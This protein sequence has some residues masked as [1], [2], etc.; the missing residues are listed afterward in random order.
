MPLIN[1]PVEKVSS[2]INELTD[3]R[4]SYQ[5]R[6]NLYN[7]LE[8]HTQEEF[9][10]SLRYESQLYRIDTML[11]VFVE[12]VFEDSANQIELESRLKGK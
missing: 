5:Q 11:K 1:Y 6:V 7:S 4:D 2:F 9:E 10:A 12:D 3:V 8:Q